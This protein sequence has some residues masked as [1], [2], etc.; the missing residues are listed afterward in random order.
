MLLLPRAIRACC[1]PLW[2]QK[3]GL[4][5]L[6]GWHTTRGGRSPGGYDD[7]HTRPRR[8]H[9]SR[10]GPT[11][12]RGVAMRLRS[13]YQFPAPNGPYQSRVGPTGERGPGARAVRNPLSF[14]PS[15]G[16]ASSV[17]E[18]ASIIAYMVQWLGS[19]RGR[20]KEQRLSKVGH[21]LSMA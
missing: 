4:R 10:V 14:R 21:M 13:P 12:R 7:H 18:P 17:F 2:R 15:L 19:W 11:G 3:L 6:R 5:R 20:H 1:R 8:P 16:K 9:L